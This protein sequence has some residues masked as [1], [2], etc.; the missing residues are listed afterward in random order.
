[1]ISSCMTAEP[2]G[3]AAAVAVL[4]QHLLGAGAALD[5]RGLQPLRDRGAHSRSRPAIFVREPLEF[6]RARVGVDDCGGARAS[7]GESMGMRDSRAPVG[8]TPRRDTVRGTD[9]E[10]S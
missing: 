2:L 9:A 6:G 4:Q 3:A 8:V 1:M 10:R 5:Q 7:A